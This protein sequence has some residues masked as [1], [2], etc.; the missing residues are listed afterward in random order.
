M[1]SGYPSLEFSYCNLYFVVPCH[2]FRDTTTVHEKQV[3]KTTIKSQD[4]C[5]IPTYFFYILLTTMFK[6]KTYICFFVMAYF[7]NCIDLKLYL[8]C[9]KGQ[10]FILSCWVVIHG[11]YLTHFLSP[12][13]SSWI[14]DLMLYLTVVKWTRINLGVQIILS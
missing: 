4:V 10:D 3:L 8:F 2:E 1:V 6:K 12:V 5:F 9:C 11:V 7:I 13:I 14:S